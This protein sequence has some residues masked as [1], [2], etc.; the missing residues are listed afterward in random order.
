VNKT[1]LIIEDDK[2][3][4][5]Y[6]QD[7]LI[8]KGFSVKILDTGTHAIETIEKIHPDIV[9]LDLGLPLVKG[10][11]VCRE[12][13]KEFSSIPVI[14]LTGK[15]AITDKINAFELG[16]DDYITKPFVAEELLLRIAARLRDRQPGGKMIEVS[17]LKMNTESMEVM[18]N[19]KQISLT[20]QEYKLLETLATN[21]DKVQSREALL[22]KIWPNSFD[23]ETRVVDVYIS[24]LR[25]KVDKGFNKKLIHSV[26][27]FGYVLKDN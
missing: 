4:Q 19:K 6:L 18:R 24:Y 22:N 17:D 8:D 13:K 7:L 21:K 2:N 20:P 1:I 16:A 14:I 23:I 15:D 11:S 27:G 10:E 5:E 25:K 26:R 3:L 9:I 12:I